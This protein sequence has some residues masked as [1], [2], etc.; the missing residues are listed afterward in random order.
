MNRFNS[1]TSHIW[2]KVWRVKYDLWCVDYT[3]V[4]KSTSFPVVVDMGSIKLI[5]KSIKNIY[6]LMKKV[7]S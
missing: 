4:S 3:R 2:S 7:A 5:L 1:V 6:D